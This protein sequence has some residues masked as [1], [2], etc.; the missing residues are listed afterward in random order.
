MPELT[1]EAPRLAH[2]DVSGTLYFVFR[3]VEKRIIPIGGGKTR[4]EYHDRE[5]KRELV[6]FDSDA[7]RRR[8]GGSDGVEW[9]A[10]TSG[11]DSTVPQPGEVPITLNI[12]HFSAHS[13][14]V[15]A[16]QARLI[17]IPQKEVP[18]YPEP[19]YF[20]LHSPSTKGVKVDGTTPG[21]L[22]IRFG[23][24]VLAHMNPP[25]KKPASFRHEISAGSYLTL[26]LPT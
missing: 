11:F 19:W 12:R 18:G 15:P 4:V 2:G 17:I 23:S 14:T 13:H 9:E 7:V 26:K 6:R 16:G 24:N 10:D 22:V 3:D 5:R 1:P 21:L 20:D 25:P 8:E